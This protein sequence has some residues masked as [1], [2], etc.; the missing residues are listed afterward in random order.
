MK[1]TFSQYADDS[2]QLLTLPKTNPA[3]DLPPLMNKQVARMSSYCRSNQLTISRVK[4]MFLYFHTSNNIPPFSPLVHLESYIIPRSKSVKA[5]GLT[6]TENL[7]WSTHCDHVANKILSGCYLIRKLK[8]IVH[9]HVLLL[10]Y[11]AHINSHLS[12]GL[13]F[14][15]ASPHAKRIFILQKRAIR[16]IA[17]VSRR[18]S[19]RD[20]FK[21]LG[22]L[23]LAC[24]LIQSA[25]IFVRSNSHLFPLNASVHSHNTR[26]SLHIH[27]SAHN[28]S[29]FSL[30][31]EYLASTLYNKL[32]NIIISSPTMNSFKHHLKLF[33][34][35]N[36]FYSINEYLSG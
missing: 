23:T 28:L 16:I 7:D 9:P 27:R 13:L 14:W 11:F 12:Y 18:H 31:P 10:V 15:G 8:Q 20:L 25:A 2:S 19:C 35:A 5:L 29:L 4:T 34:T 6:L 24:T 33:L 1:G 22:V 30:G 26:A 3:S 21:N 36:S 17:G 32:P